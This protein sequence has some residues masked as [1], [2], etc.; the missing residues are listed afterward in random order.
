MLGFGA[1]Q[2]RRLLPP[3]S[4]K[5]I[6]MSNPQLTTIEISKEDLKFSAA[7]FTIF[8]ATERERLHG[9]NF[10][11]ALELTAEVG[12]NGMCFSYAEIKSRLRKL[13]AQLDEYLILPEQSPHLQLIETS[14]CY[15][16]TFAGE[17]MSF[18]KSDTRLLPIRNTTIEE[19]SRYLLDRLLEDQ[20]FMS[21][22]AVRQL[23]MKVSSGAG[24]WGT[25]CWVAA[26]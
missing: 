13:C 26:N 7:H 14:D 8:S 10:R 16:A 24:Q 18:L 11:V 21:D 1:E 15:I 22:N 6:I 9:H 4:C 25:C 12:D 19:F 20:A 2:M 3:Q 23:V 5:T 17:E